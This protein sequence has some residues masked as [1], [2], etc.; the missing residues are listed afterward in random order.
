MLKVKGKNKVN[1]GDSYKN[2]QTFDV[3]WVPIAKPDNPNRNA[4]SDHVWAQGRALGAATFQRLEGCWSGADRKI[5]IVST[6][7]G[8]G[9]GQIWVLQPGSRK[10]FAAVRISWQG[11][12]RQAGSHDRQ[13][14]RR[15]RALRGR[16]RRRVPARPDD[17]RPDLLV[18]AE[19]REAARRA[20]RPYRRLHSPNGPARATARMES[21]CSPTSSIPG[22]PWRSRAPGSPA[23]LGS[24]G[25]LSSLG[26]LAGNPLFFIRAVSQFGCASRCGCRALSSHLSFLQA[27]GQKTDVPTF[28]VV[29][30]R[31][32]DADPGFIP[33]SPDRFIDVNATLK[34]LI[35]W[36]WN[37]RD[38]QVSGG[39][40]WADSRRFDV[41]ARSPRPVSEATMRLMVQRLLADRFQL[42]T[43]VEPR[44][45][46]RCVLRT[47]RQDA[48]LGPGLTPAPVNC[49][50]VLAAR[51]GAPRPMAARS[52]RA[53]GAWASR[54]RWRE[55]SW[56]AR[57]CRSSRGCS[58]GSSAQGRRCHGPH[59]R[60]HPPRV[61]LRS[62]ADGR[63]AGRRARCPCTRR[64]LVVHRVGGSARPEAPVRTGSGRCHRDRVG[65][66]AGAQLKDHR[67]NAN[68]AWS[69]DSA[70][71]HCS[72]SIC[73]ARKPNVIPLP[74]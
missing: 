33:S 74:P 41:S 48:A 54:R 49:A 3:E 39:P 63:A 51:F 68:N 36:A 26:S 65:A 8:R 67:R 2:G 15:A 20:Q 11:R 24:L 14:T 60:R 5:Y 21:G 53:C 58:S 30:I 12:P 16:R 7:G 55:C 1:L 29:S 46:P 32:Q 69:A 73:A 13:P 23:R 40:P 22:S 31:P 71:R 44:Q 50:D 27:G 70:P 62:I 4:P 10:H 28:E 18:R 6:N 45:M 43:R 52:P 57:R 9:Q 17:R 34:S 19:Q 66:A 25:C 59:R 56:T 42:R 35:T 64:A 61:L 72:S 38:F 47:A 37:V